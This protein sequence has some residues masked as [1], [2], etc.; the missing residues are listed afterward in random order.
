MI[1]VHAP[2]TGLGH[3]TRVLA[4]HHTLGWEGS[5]VVLSSAPRLDEVP[6]PPGVE[7]RAIPAHVAGERTALRAHLRRTIAELEPD[8]LWVDALPAGMWGEVDRG[9]VDEALGDRPVHHLARLVRWD[10]YRRAVGTDL[11]HFA[12]VC[13]VEPLHADHEAALR[14]RAAQW[15]EVVLTDAPAP[16]APP[17]PA[18]AWLVLHSGPTP[19]TDDLVEHARARRDR[20]APGAPL[21]VA[22]P[23]DGRCP[24]ADVHLTGIVPAWPLLAAADHVVAAAGC[25]TVRQLSAA[26]TSADLVPMPRRWDDQFTRARRFRSALAGGSG[27]TPGTP[28]T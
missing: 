21:V 24:R 10:P 8:E 4:A 22:T 25:N 14:S 28:R 11:P 26:G 17:L 15:S 6:P 23:S 2:G 1:L 16:P 13:A 12:R 18:G 9:L 5:V 3:V 27:A 19:E 7:L 20:R